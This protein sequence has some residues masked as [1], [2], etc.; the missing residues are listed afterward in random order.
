MARNSSEIPSGGK[1]F[2]PLIYGGVEVPF[3]TQGEYS[4]EGRLALRLEGPVA[5]KRFI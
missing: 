3:L 2:V 1:P 5:K 4:A